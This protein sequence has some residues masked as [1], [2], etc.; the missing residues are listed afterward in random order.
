MFFNRNKIILSILQPN[1]I[2]DTQSR[3]YLYADEIYFGVKN[4]GFNVARTRPRVFPGRNV[5]EYE[6]INIVSDGFT[7][8]M[9]T[10][11]DGC[12]NTYTNLRLDDGN[13]V[14]KFTQTVAATQGLSGS[15]DLIYD[16]TR[17][18]IPYKWMFEEDKRNVLDILL[19]NFGWDNMWIGFEGNWDIKK[20]C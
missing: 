14:T 11:K 10:T 7:V 9:K 6:A 15:F 8:R 2:R 20:T 17:L 4:T 3:S 12:H 5:F 19:H 13:S 16:G 18:T 1:Y